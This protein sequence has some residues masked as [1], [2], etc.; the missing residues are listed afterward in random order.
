M[1]NKNLT[2]K[3]RIRQLGIVFLTIGGVLFLNK[4]SFST[5][6]L[7]AGAFFFMLYYFICSFSKVKK[8]TDWELVFPELA[9]G[10]SDEV[11]E[12]EE[13]VEN[14]KA[15]KFELQRILFHKIYHISSAILIATLS[16]KF[17]LWANNLTNFMVL[18]RLLNML[19]ILTILILVAVHFLSIFAPIKQKYDWSLVYPELKKNK[20]K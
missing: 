10:S 13:P 6:M 17:F 12:D 20:V 1:Y 11:Y 19:L 8:T 15:N 14:L 16:V 2:I 3:M 4:I 7:S 9:L 5:F 18:N